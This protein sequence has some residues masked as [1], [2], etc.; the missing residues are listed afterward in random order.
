MRDK[1]NDSQGSAFENVLA[2]AMHRMMSDAGKWALLPM[3]PQVRGFSGS[4]GRAWS[5]TPLQELKQ[6]VRFKLLAYLLRLHPE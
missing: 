2:R 1:V 4:L 3:P 6:E 5:R